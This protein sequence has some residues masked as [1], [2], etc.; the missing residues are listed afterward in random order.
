MFLNW[1]PR[2]LWHA[3]SS[4]RPFRH[5][6]LRKLARPRLEP[7]E[8]RVLLTVFTVINTN[9]SG[10]GSLRQAIL[11]ANADPFVDTIA[12]AVDGGGVQTIRPLSSLPAVTNQVTIDATFQPGYAETPLIVLDGSV[13]GANVSGLT[14]AAGNS[15]V[16]GLV[17]NNFGLYGIALATRGGDILQNNYLGTDATGTQPLGNDWGV[18]IGAGVTNCI[19]GGTGA[20]DSNLVSG[21]RTG[22][23]IINVNAD[24]NVVEGNYIGTDASGSTALGNGVL[25]PNGG[26]LILGLGNTIGGTSRGAGNLISG[27]PANGVVIDQGGNFVR[28]NFIGTDATG[29]RAL[30]NF[31]GVSVEN[32]SNVI[33][34]TDPGAGNLISGNTFGGVG[35]A[36]EAYDNLLEGNYI[37]TDV[38]GTQALGN[39]TGVGD[40]AFVGNTIGGTS[41]G[42]G[43]LISGN[44]GDGV[45]IG[46]SSRV[47][48]NYIGTDA[49]GTQALPNGGSGVQIGSIAA[50]VTIGGTADGAGNV[51]SGN[52][53]DGIT[54]AGSRT[55]IQGNYIGTDVTGTQAV[56]NG[57]SGVQ[58]A[59]GSSNNTIGGTANGAGNV[60]SGNAADGIYIQG[61]STT[62]IVVQGNQIGTDITGTL[63]LGN[64][65]NGVTVTGGA[66]DNTIG[67]AAPRATNVI[68]FNGGDG[69]LVDGGTSNAIRLNSIFANGGL[70]IDLV[71]G[72]NHNE[73]A[74]VITS[75]TSGGG[76]TMIQ[77][78]LQA[79]P[80]STFT[81]DLF[82]NS[83]GDGQ[84]ER[85]LGSITVTT[86]ASGHAV[87]TVIFAVDV[88]PGESIT[89]TATDANGNTSRFSQGVLVTGA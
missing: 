64:G 70:G 33:G 43:N 77:G 78:T 41:P 18:I 58:M 66:H 14:I 28:G 54:V 2:R 35:F 73:P 68:A 55:V 74:P 71:N 12:F 88:L 26:V 79:A 89:A 87:F 42:A 83:D 6:L 52:A 65:G 40:S 29:T 82:A 7:L 15:T 22:G 9:D 47:Q 20:T 11:D 17:V 38:T 37:G 62:A 46:R 67:G 39:G 30:P 86:D 27:N 4:G 34:G 60:I 21:N 53:A 13:A 3:C 25:G 51:I 69:V 48:G 85:F 80:N 57:S 81:L 8:D 19:I 44:R 76:I 5:P 23:I 36:P 59:S 63:A 16:R 1:L 61:P 24:G 32:S 72:G 49:T 84:G 56:P 50:N 31:V 10:A 75:A 45:S